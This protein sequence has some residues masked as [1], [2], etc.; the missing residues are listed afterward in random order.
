MPDKPNTP[1]TSRSS[2]R[3]LRIID[4]VRPHWKGLTLAFVAVL[5]ETL[6]AILEPWPIKVVVDNILQS[7]AAAGAR[8]AAS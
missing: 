8:W 4:L 6:T 1:P 5:G 2:P 7:K 3:A